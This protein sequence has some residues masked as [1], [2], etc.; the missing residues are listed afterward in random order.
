MWH[1]FPKKFNHT[2]EFWYVLDLLWFFCSLFCCFV[3]VFV[4]RFNA[5]QLM[6]DIYCHVRIAYGI[7]M[8]GFTIHTRPHY[9]RSI[10][11][12]FIQFYWVLLV[13][14]HSAIMKSKSCSVVGVLI[15]KFISFNVARLCVCEE[16]FW[17]QY[18]QMHLTECLYIFFHITH[19]HHHYHNRNRMMSIDSSKF[20]IHLDK[21]SIFGSI[22]PSCIRCFHLILK[23]E[24][25]RKCFFHLLYLCYENEIIW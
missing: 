4:G 19:H 22:S 2:N 15:N 11:K 13:I 17:T 12:K 6:Y 25:F 20:T 16:L 10:S 9:I 21:M 7:C 14:L 23:V 1:K 5:R 3:S 8:I 24:I 18:A